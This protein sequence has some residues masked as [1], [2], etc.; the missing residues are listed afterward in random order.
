[1]RER[2]AADA[3]RRDDDVGW[4][5]DAFALV[6]DARKKMDGADDGVG[7]WLDILHAFDEVAEREAE[8]AVAPGEKSERIGV[9]IDRATADFVVV[10]NVAKSVPVHEFVFDFSTVLVGANSAL[11]L[12]AGTGLKY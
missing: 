4:R 2:F 10:G 8:Q 3:A 7:C 6:V 5:F 9:A 11:I 12:V 1:M